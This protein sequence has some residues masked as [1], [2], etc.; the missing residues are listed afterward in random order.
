MYLPG[1]IAVFVRESDSTATKSYEIFP[2][3]TT[4]LIDGKPVT[5][6]PDLWSPADFE[7]QAPGFGSV[8]ENSIDITIPDVITIKA[9]MTDRIPWSEIFPESGP[10][11]VLLAAPI[12]LHWYVSS[13]GSKASYEYSVGDGPVV[14]SEGF[15]HM[16]KNW[17]G[18][19][20][21]SWVWAQGTSG[22]NTSHFALA[23]GK[24]KIGPALITPWF[25][26]YRSPSVAWNFNPAVAGTVYHTEIDACSGNFYMEAKN[27]AHTLIIEASADPDTF[28]PV[29]IPTSDGWKKNGGVES[30]S[31][32]IKVRAYTH[33]PIGG[34]FGIE[35]LVD[36]RTFRNA[37]IEFGAG[38]ICQELSE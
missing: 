8:T 31:S 11:G 14:T 1:Y 32:T 9:T 28:A 36:K 7:W 10:E 24:I 38:Y 12:P 35:R 22:N 21:H 16:E 23:G 4:V 15:A 33:S 18:T 2:D 34:L 30:F 37:V 27:P 13:V 29:S 26:G 20:P 17:G 5:E 6:N 19:F 3:K 25:V